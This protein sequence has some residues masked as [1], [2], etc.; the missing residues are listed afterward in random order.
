MHCRSLQ[1]LMN[2]RH[3]RSLLKFQSRLPACF[4][5]TGNDPV[6]SGPLFA[7]VKT[8]TFRVPWKS[9]RM[10]PRADANRLDSPSCEWL[11]LARFA[12][13]VGIR[14]MPQRQT[15]QFGAFEKA[16]VVVVQRTQRLITIFPKD[17]ESEIAEQLPARRD[18]AAAGV[19]IN[20]PSR[21]N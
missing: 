4:R 9:L 11:H 14:V 17:P 6:V 10:R 5:M 13:A 18:F 8:D 20:E 12:L 1:P 16:I 15:C 21:L 19:I 2:R 7:I 3:L